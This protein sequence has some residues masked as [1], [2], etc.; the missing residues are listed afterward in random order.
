[1]CAA[2]KSVIDAFAAPR[3]RPPPPGSRPAR[4]APGRRGLARCRRSRRR[5]GR[6]RH[7]RARLGAGRWRGPPPARSASR[8][9]ASSCASESVSTSARISA[10]ARL[11]E[12]H[13][14]AR[15]PRNT[16]A[17]AHLKSAGTRG[18]S[19]H[20]GAARD[21]RGLVVEH[22]ALARRHG[23]TDEVP[24]VPRRRARMGG[25]RR[26]VQP[27]SRAAMGISRCLRSGSHRSR[28]L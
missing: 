9:A 23:T 7:R 13:A 3:A 8:S 17:R 16:P 2:P 26:A 1:M 25:V 27:D 24:N 4:R 6:P 22:R 12:R 5:R 11:A 28:R 20:A 21:Q 10:D 14:A 15:P 19:S 18:G